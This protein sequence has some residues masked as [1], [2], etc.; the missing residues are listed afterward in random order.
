V[1]E[2]S[3]WSCNSGRTFLFGCSPNSRGRLTCTQL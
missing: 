2:G 1:D 3:S